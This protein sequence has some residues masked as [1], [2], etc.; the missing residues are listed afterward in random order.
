MRQILHIVTKP[1]DKLAAEIVA[2]QR[3]Q[4]NTA[5]NVA[6]LTGKAP[7]YEKLLED[8]FKADS[9]QVW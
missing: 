2:A 3:K 8:I 4:P 5:V 7:D 9:I 6:D 1:D